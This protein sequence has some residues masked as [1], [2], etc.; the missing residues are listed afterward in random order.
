[1]EHLSALAYEEDVYWAA[2]PLSGAQRPSS[3]K[4]AALRPWP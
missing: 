2:G 3:I 1:M 4:G